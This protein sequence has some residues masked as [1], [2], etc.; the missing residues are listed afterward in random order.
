MWQSDH[1]DEEQSVLR[2][3]GRCRASHCTGLSAETGL[4]PDTTQRLVGPSIRPVTPSSFCYCGLGDSD[5]YQGFIY[6]EL[7]NGA[8][9]VG[10][11]VV[12][13]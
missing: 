6:V 10:S 9:E 12:L 13:H 7:A 11:R 1:L 4:G 8:G 3:A 2:Q 5:C